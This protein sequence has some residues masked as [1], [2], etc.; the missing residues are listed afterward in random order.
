MNKNVSFILFDEWSTSFSMS[1]APFRLDYK[2]FFL[3][4]FAWC[5]VMLWGPHTE[6]SAN[7]CL[8]SYSSHKFVNPPSPSLSL[9]M[10]YLQFCWL[11]ACRKQ[12]PRV[13][14]IVVVVR[15]H[16]VTLVSQFII[17][18]PELWVIFSSSSLSRWSCHTWLGCG[19]LCG[20]GRAATGRCSLLYHV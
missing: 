3:F 9:S 12:M 2:F 4:V 7:I 16:V 5:D 15:S 8:A 10:F 19:H 1:S 6:R 11:V 20:C 14:W 13:A 17:P 18:L